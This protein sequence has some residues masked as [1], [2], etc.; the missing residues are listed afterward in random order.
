MPNYGWRYLLGLTSV[1]L[2]I[3]GLFCFRLPES[4]RY[5]L[6]VGENDKALATL[7]EISRQN[8]KSL[9]EGRLISVK[10]CS[11]IIINFSCY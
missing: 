10:V 5:H 6:A 3:F 1:P 9:P 11:F 4:A 7:E 8:K 2:A